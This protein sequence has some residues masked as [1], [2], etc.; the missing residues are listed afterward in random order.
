MGGGEVKVDKYGEFWSGVFNKK[1]LSI[2]LD[3]HDHLLCEIVEAAE[4]NDLE[5]KQMQISNFM[6]YGNPSGP[7]RTFNSLQTK[8]NMTKIVRLLGNK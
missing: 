7:L 6:K 1:N 2:Q 3:Y 4:N 8:Q 5:K